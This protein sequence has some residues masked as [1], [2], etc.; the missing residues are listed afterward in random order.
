MGHGYGNA[1]RSRAFT[2]I[3]KLP[4]QIFKQGMGRHDDIVNKNENKDQ[5]IAGDAGNGSGCWWCSGLC[6][7]T[8]ASR[9][10]L[11]NRCPDPHLRGCRCGHDKG[12]TVSRREN[13]LGHSIGRI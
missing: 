2:G 11:G 8:V 5:R 1:Y 10:H 3:H 4:D 12:G 6:N 13:V 9:I 7:R